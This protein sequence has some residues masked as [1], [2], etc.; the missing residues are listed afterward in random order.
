MLPRPT[1]STARVSTRDSVL[2]GRRAAGTAREFS[3][4]LAPCIGINYLYFIYIKDICIYSSI[5]LLLH[6]FIPFLCIYSGI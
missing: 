2:F 6:L 5:N 1:P 3:T 4:N